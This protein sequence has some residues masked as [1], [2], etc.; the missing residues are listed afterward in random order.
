MTPVWLMVLCVTIG[1]LS[2][3]FYNYARIKK[4]DE[5]TDEMIQ[6]SAIIRSGS[7]T[8]LKTEFRSIW[9]VM[10]LVA[11]IFSLFIEKTSGLSFILGGSMSSIV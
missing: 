8:F 9:I 5:G 1:A 6:M 11:L 4:M 7:E 3:I 2:Y 10:I